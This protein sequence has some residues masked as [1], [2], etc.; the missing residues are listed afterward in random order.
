MRALT[1]CARRFAGDESGA[2]SIEYSL[3]AALVAVGVLAAMQA[4]G[5]GVSGSWGNTAQ[6]VSDAMKSPS[7]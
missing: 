3:I 4:L 2:T 5:G 7:P 1:D 6:K